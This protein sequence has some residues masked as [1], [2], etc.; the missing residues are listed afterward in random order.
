MKIAQKYSAQ[1]HTHGN[2]CQP[3]IYTMRSQLS[4]VPHGKMSPSNESWFL[5]QHCISLLWSREDRAWDIAWRHQLF[6]NFWSAIAHV[7]RAKV[8][9]SFVH[10][11]FYESEIWGWTTGFQ[12]GVAFSKWSH[13][14]LR[15]SVMPHCFVNQHLEIS[16]CIC[17]YKVLKSFNFPI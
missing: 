16:L 3:L 5:T 10:F 7:S 1:W 15:G 13:W 17:S 4:L 8:F 2:N 6:A 9:A 12:L 14:R 11:G